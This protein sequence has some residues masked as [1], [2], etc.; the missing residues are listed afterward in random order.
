MSP[1]L[2][3]TRFSCKQRAD[4]MGCMGSQETVPE[5]DTASCM[6]PWSRFPSFHWI[7]FYH[8]PSWYVE[9]R[10]SAMSSCCPRLPSGPSIFETD[11]IWPPAG[12]AVALSS[13]P[14]S[15]SLEWAKRTSHCQ[16]CVLGALPSLLHA[17]LLM[18]AHPLLTHISKFASFI[19]FSLPNRLSQRHKRHRKGTQSMPTFHLPPFFKFIGCFVI[20]D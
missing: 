19:S 16:R 6:W 18:S 7:F 1:A 2:S 20:C 8:L 4:I 17:S 14:H 3:I 15:T 13:D 5:Y 11:C 10:T 12:P 9:W